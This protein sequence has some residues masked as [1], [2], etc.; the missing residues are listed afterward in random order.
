VL[1][2]GVIAQNPYLREV[3]ET[4]LGEWALHPS[5]QGLRIELSTLENAPLE[6]TKLLEK[7]RYG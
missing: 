6:G 1:G 5:L 2:G 7:R 3:L 4:R